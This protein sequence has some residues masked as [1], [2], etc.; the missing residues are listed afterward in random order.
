MYTPQMFRQDIVEVTKDGYKDIN[1]KKHIKSYEDILV[2]LED[3]EVSNEF[4]WALGNVVEILIADFISGKGISV[5]DDYTPT[6]E[7]NTLVEDDMAYVDTNIVYEDQ[8]IAGIDEPV[9]RISYQ[10]P[11]N[12]F[13]ND[14]TIKRILN[15]IKTEFEEQLRSQS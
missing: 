7:F 14:E 1:G 9:F 11:L 15:N 10:L 8:E 5:D 6:N 4:N 13:H 2:N 12:E 3:D